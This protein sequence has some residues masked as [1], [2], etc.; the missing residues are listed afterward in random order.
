MGL[1]SEKY[2]SHDLMDGQSRFFASPKLPNSMQLF[3]NLLSSPLVSSLRLI[4]DYECLS[5]VSWS[6]F[7]Q[8]S[9]FSLSLWI[10]SQRHSF[11]YHQCSHI[12]HIYIRS[13]AYFPKSSK[14]MCIVLLNLTFRDIKL[15]GK[16]YNYKPCV[17]FSQV[18]W[19][20]HSFTI[21]KRHVTTN[22]LL[23]FYDP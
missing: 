7:L 19:T 11:L 9:K 4:C 8:A 23:T 22:N 15:T 18:V 5:C 12:T 1:T 21:N 14:E 3:W 2:C 6:Y 17:L 13:S 10:Q 16:A 20:Q